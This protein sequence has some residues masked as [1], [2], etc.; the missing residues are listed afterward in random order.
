[1]ANLFARYYAHLNPCISN[2]LPLP[3]SKEHHSQEGFA[4]A[5][6]KFYQNAAETEAP[7]L[8]QH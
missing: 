7:C 2:P 8:C 1:M 6:G 5:A 3:I 4:L